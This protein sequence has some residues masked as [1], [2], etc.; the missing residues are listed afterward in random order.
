MWIRDYGPFSVRKRDGQ[1]VIL[2]AQYERSLNRSNDDCVPVVVAEQLGMGLVRAPIVLEGGNLLSNGDGLCITTTALLDSNAGRDLDENGICQ[3]LHTYFGAR[4]TVFLE[5]LIGESTGH[6]DMFAVFL[7]RETVVV[8]SYDPLVDPVNAAVLDRN[9]AYLAQIR[10]RRGP[11]RVVRVPM[12]DNSDGVWRSYTNTI[13]ANGVLMVPVYTDA[14]A[15]LQDVALD[16]FRR[17]LPGWKV[18]PIDAKDTIRCGGAL[19]CISKSI[20]SLQGGRSRHRA[21]GI[22][23]RRSQAATPA[24]LPPNE[25]C[26]RPYWAG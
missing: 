7:S 17:H 24:P 26:L 4:Q 19:H 10:T 25:R 8:G 14:D 1:V 5:P 15:T 18:V 12:P 9:A 20:L 21:A 2:D 23:Q 22:A 11:L 13:F 6:V 3:I 16:S